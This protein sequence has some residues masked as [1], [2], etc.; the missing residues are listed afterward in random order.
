MKNICRFSIQVFGIVLIVSP[1][2][3]GCTRINKYPKGI[4]I[5]GVAGISRGNEDII[6][7]GDCGPY[8][9]GKFS[10]TYLDVGG[11]LETSNGEGVTTVFTLGSI[12]TTRISEPRWFDTT[13]QTGLPSKQS[14]LYSQ[15][16]VSMDWDNFGWEIGA[17]FAD[18]LYN[19]DPMFIPTLQFRVG[20][21][22]RFYCSVGTGRTTSYMATGSVL[23]FGM[24]FNIP[25]IRTHFWTGAGWHPQYANTQALF[26]FET[27]VTNSLAI[28]G[29]F[30][31]GS[32]FEDQ[33]QYDL[34]EY[35]VSLGL[36]I[37]LK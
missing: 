32:V 34:P 25:E 8:S 27:A 22:E 16:K 37:K 1:W 9:I 33:K 29:S 11:S 20:N 35:G 2:M 21:T 3:F 24:G 23:D 7:P 18:R 10:P 31:N 4:W 14:A 5:E 17:S 26:Q 12:S 13:E 36:K 30:N 19:T 6:I 28:K 15:V